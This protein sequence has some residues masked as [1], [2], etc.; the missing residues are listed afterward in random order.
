[1]TP[2][3]IFSAA[4]AVAL[5]SWIL[6]AVF[7]RRRVVT[8]VL[9][10]TIVPAALA[11]AYSLIVL[12]VWTSSDGSFATLG[13]VSTLF[14]N[15]WLLLAGWIHYLAFDLLMG[16]WELRDAQARGIPHACVV[17]CLALTFL[18]GPAGWL[19]YRGVAALGP[20]R[21]STPRDG[22]TV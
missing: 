7:P 8:D 1:M 5:I 14:S 10:G 21:D 15:P 20:R 19:L 2:E 16:R 12:A 6:L 17:P 22:R 9:A 13:G 11:V 4:N 18:F 3:Q